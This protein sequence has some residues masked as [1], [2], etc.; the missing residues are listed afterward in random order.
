MDLLFI[1][2]FYNVLWNEKCNKVLN[3]PRL[4][5]AFFCKT[6]EIQFYVQERFIYNPYTNFL[7]FFF[8]NDFFSRL[9]KIYRTFLVTLSLF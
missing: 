3:G 5:P 8:S 4:L 6:I 7:M 9:L 1:I 2:E